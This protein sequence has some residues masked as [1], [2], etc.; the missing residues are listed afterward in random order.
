MLHNLL[1]IIIDRQVDN[2]HN[3]GREIERISPPIEKIHIPEQASIPDSCCSDSTLCDSSAVDSL[4]SNFGFLGDNISNS[5][6]TSHVIIS[7]LV[8]IA[9][10]SLCLYM[11]FRIKKNKVHI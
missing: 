8:A 6:G 10:L 5:G 11:V 4:S 1:D 9:A 2:S 7:I 3:A